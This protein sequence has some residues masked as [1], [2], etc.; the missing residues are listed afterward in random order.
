MIGQTYG[1]EVWSGPG[2]YE[3]ATPLGNGLFLFVGDGSEAFIR[4][5]VP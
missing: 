5:Y 4:K 1:G 2:A 3:L